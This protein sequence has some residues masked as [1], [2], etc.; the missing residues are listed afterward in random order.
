MD[1]D[2]KEDYDPEAVHAAF[3]KGLPHAMETAR[4]AGE[5]LAEH[6]EKTAGPTPQT[7]TNKVAGGKEGRGQK[8]PGSV[9]RVSGHR[10]GGR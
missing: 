8:I 10:W 2:P 4:Y 7:P 3:V 5:K 1:N 6:F 9:G